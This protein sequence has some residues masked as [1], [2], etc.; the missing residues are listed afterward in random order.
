MASNLCHADRRR[1]REHVDR[2]CAALW[3][4]TESQSAKVQFT[5]IFGRVSPNEACPAPVGRVRGHTAAAGGLGARSPNSALPI[6]SRYR[7][8]PPYYSTSANSRAPFYL[9]TRSEILQ[10]KSCQSSSRSGGDSCAPAHL[11]LCLAS[12][13][14]GTPGAL[15][16]SRAWCRVVGHR[17]LFFQRT[18]EW[19]SDPARRDAL[20]P[21]ERRPGSLE[22]EGL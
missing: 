22:G 18:V 14:R 17:P 12:R 10:A 11:P 3:L 21:G 8:S 4:A 16:K 7:A 19:S 1:R 5:A 2:A 20:L 9:T 6:I 13:H 15:C